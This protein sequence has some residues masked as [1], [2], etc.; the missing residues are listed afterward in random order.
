[1]PTES[2]PPTNRAKWHRVAISGLAGF[3]IAV[4][5]SQIAAPLTIDLLLARHFTSGQHLV[6]MRV[7]LFGFPLVGLAAG[8]CLNWLGLIFRSHG[9]E[10]RLRWISWGAV[11]GLALLML[12]IRI[13]I[14]WDP[15]LQN[16]GIGFPGSRI[17]ISLEDAGILSAPA[18]LVC[19]GFIGWCCHRWFK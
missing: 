19:G 8:I 1:M 3:V 18:A 10:D 2:L 6:L 15:N 9:T 7:W 14:G 17:E 4:L 5:I 12:L 16:R 13:T 11:L